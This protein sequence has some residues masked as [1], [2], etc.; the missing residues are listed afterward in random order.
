[1]ARV[2]RKYT[3]GLGM[4][5][6]VRM[7]SGSKEQR[8]TQM[9]LDQLPTYGI[10]SDLPR[11][12]IRE[13]IE[14]LIS[15]GYLALS[16]GEYPVLGLTAQAREVLFCGQTVSIPVKQQP[17]AAQ[18]EGSGRKK[19]RRREEAGE[20]FFENPDDALM[21]R[22]RALRFRLAR[23]AQVPAYVIFTNATLSA[24]AV[25]RPTTTAELLDIPGVGEKRAFRY[26]AAFLELIR[27]FCG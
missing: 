16:Q 4:T 26:G 21:E 11:N 15:S 12:V 22:L 10:L 8:I 9:G 1:M 23:E 3:Y 19:R 14:H 27:D 18:I 6:Y 13:Y 25:R 24:M 7:L 20:V 17:P 5:M 2:E